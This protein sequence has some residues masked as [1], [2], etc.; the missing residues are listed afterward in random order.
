MFSFLINR[1]DLYSSLMLV[2]AHRGSI[3]PMVSVHILWLAHL[4]YSSWACKFYAYI[5]CTLSIV[6]KEDLL[7][8][9]LPVL[10]EYF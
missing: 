6:G 4:S 3:E 7:T 5:C 8:Q 9:S 1:L 2:Q 10:L